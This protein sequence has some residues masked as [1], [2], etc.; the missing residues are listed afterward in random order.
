MGL[1][2][3]ELVLEF[4]EEFEIAIPDAMACE[5]IDIGKTVTG[6]VKLLAE[7]ERPL[8][9]CSTAHAFYRLRQ[10]SMARFDTPRSMVRL[11]VP[12]GMLVPPSRDREWKQIAQSSGLRCGR[13]NRKFPNPKL[14]LRQVIKDRAKGGWQRADGS[15]DETAVF[16]RVREI[17]SE[18]LGV[19]VYKLF[20]DTRYID[21]LGAG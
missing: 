1:D 4:E 16:Q 13:T 20:A 11:D 7:K 12:I 21:D 6:I 17:V 9:A 19:S 10:N 2:T 14:T 8:V 3:V 5:M 15:I 18:Q